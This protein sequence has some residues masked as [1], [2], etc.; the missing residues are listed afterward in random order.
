[1]YRKWEDEEVFIEQ[2][3]RFHGETALHLTHELLMVY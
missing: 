3:E 2:W 1:M